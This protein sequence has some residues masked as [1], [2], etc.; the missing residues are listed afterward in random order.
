MANLDFS[1]ILEVILN[2]VFWILEKEGINLNTEEEVKEIT[3]F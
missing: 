2:F 1:K 3:K